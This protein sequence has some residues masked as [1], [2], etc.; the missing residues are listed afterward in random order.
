VEEIEVRVRGHVD[1]DWADSLGGMTITHTGAGES[2]ITGPV[3]DQSAL[4]SLVNRLSGLGLRLV[5]VASNE[6]HPWTQGGQRDVKP[7]R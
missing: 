5:S 2:I 3:R 4:I 1:A 7:E 6:I